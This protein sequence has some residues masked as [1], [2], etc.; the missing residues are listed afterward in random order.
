[1]APSQTEPAANFE[2]RRQGGLFGFVG[3]AA[4]ATAVAYAWRSGTNVSTVGW[5][6]AAVLA[7]VA[8]ANL[9]AWALARTP[10]LVADEHGLRLR[11][12]HTWVGLP[13]TEI[14]ELVILPRRGLLRDGALTVRTA[15]RSFMLPLGLAAAASADDPAGTLQ[16]LADGRAEVRTDLAAAAPE[17]GPMPDDV[18]ALDDEPVP[19][20]SPGDAPREPEPEP[21]PPPDGVYAPVARAAGGVD[22]EGGVD[23]PSFIPARPQLAALRRATRAVT[24]PVAS[25]GRATRAQV[26]RDGP[27][28]FGMLA[29]QGD[30]AE[31]PEVKELRGTQG[32]VGLVIEQIATPLD[33][34][35][36]GISTDPAAEPTAAEPTAAEL[37]AAEPMQEPVEPAPRLIG[38]TLAMARQ[39]L[40]LDVDALA[41]RTRIRP[42]VIEAM[43]ADDF[44]ACGGDFYARGHL[45]A[46]ARTLGID[47]T[48]L[49]AVYDRSFAA[50]PINARQ[51]F[52]AELAQGRSST[53]RLA[54]GGPNW[55][56]LIGVVLVLALLWGVAR[57]MTST[58][59]GTGLPATGHPGARAGVAPIDP[60]R[61][62]GLG[63]GRD[64]AVT[65][66]ATADSRV[67]VT[68]ADGSLVWRGVI[69]AGQSRHWS[70]PGPVRVVAAHGAAVSAAVDGTQRGPLGPGPHRAVASL[71]RR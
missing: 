24:T 9:R 56:A 25:A 47:G 52:E 13:W 65:L 57:V 36:V 21:D 17:L 61:F 7:V 45:R 32:R 39:R 14:D 67:V 62:A 41:E 50:E 60:G 20:C 66:H 28:T 4:T 70:A 2:V 54:R 37:T 59:G 33:K 44:S 40:R 18:A 1:M 34:S 29:L 5:L 69:R 8:V 27:A 22:N 64:V 11:R 68:A 42:H 55:A 48:D 16:S 53:V 23:Q 31:L 49:V 43:E 71:G 35:Q 58:S 38:D 63:G 15:G 30:P 3:L 51:V 6:V 19:D 12:G 10:L 26:R 46:V